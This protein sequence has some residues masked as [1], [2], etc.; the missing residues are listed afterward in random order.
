MHVL[1]VILSPNL[2]GVGCYLRGHAPP[3]RPE[4]R[5]LTDRCGKGSQKWA[6]THQQKRGFA[7][8]GAVAA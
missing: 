4:R 5:R 6:M 7:P 8:T 1:A 3:E 2:T